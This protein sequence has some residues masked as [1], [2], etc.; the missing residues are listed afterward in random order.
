MDSTLL[1][2]VLFLNAAFSACSA[3]AMVLAA[4]WV[5]AQLGLAGVTFVYVTAAFLFLFS[6]RLGAIVYNEDFSSRKIY[7]IIVGDAVW[8]FA[9]IVLTS[10]FYDSLTFTGFLV[11]DAIALAV[12]LF[13][14]FQFWGLRKVQIKA[15]N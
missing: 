2:R 8:V 15:S 10:V 7:P 3:I 6:M 1:V 14:V 5:V 11:V 13:A 12:L 9:T 4:N